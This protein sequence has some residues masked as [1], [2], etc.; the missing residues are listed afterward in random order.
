LQSEIDQAVAREVHIKTTPAEQA[1]LTPRRPVH[2][3]AFDDYLQGRHLYLNKR[4]EENLGK[5][6]EYFQSAIRQDPAYASAYAALADCYN[7]Q[8]QVMFSVLQPTEARRRAEEAAE[9]ALALDAE[10]AEAHAALGSINHL[11]WNWAAA[12]QQLKRAIELNPNY[13][14][15]HSVYAAYLM[16]RGRAEEALAASNRARELDP[17]SLSLGAQRGFLLE[18]ARR[19]DEAIEQLR[20]VI[21]VEPNQYQAYWFLG[22]TYAANGQFDEAVAA[23][24]KA[25]ALSGRAP[26]ALGILGLV[27]GLAGRRAEA[28]KVLNELLELNERR[29]VTPGALANVYIGLGDKDQAFVWLEKAYQERSYYMIWLKVWPI[30]DPLRSDARFGDLMRRVGL[31]Q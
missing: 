10:L 5:A 8:G 24:E 17:L 16:S 28:Q 25:V 19:Y 20:R 23:S 2:P 12:E 21:A 27:Y 3:K 1:R 6:I 14:N 22:H 11:N 30:V 7:V 29:Y 13:A 15:A 9:K 18:N 4:T 26:G 31:P